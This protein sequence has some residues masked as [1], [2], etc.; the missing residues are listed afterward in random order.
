MLLGVSHANPVRVG[1]IGAGTFGTC[2]A[3]MAGDQGHAVTL[4]AREPGVADA[5]NRHRRNPRYLTEFR[6]P[7]G[8]RG[9]ADLE[10]AVRD[11][12]LILFVIPSHAYRETWKRAAHCV[13]GEPLIVSATK[14]LEV[15]T[16]LLMSQVAR[17]VLPSELHPRMISLSGPSFAREL[18]EGRPSAVVL[19]CGNEPYAIAAQ[20]LLSSS[21]LRCYTN[22]DVIGVEL[23][24]ALK[25][26]IAIAV[27][28]CDGMGMGL[29]AR[30]ALISRG[31]AEITRLGVRMGARPLTF[32]GLSGLGDLILTCTGDLSRNRRVG[33]AI[34]RGQ[35]LEDVLAGLHEV[36]EGVPTARAA[37]ELA[38]KHEVD[39]PITE[40]V[41]R[42]LCEGKRP[43]EAGAALMS[44]QLRS[45]AE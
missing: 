4:W 5:M 37:H 23:G 3:M 41:H 14:G 24:G 22:P 34:G 10:E 33:I 44:R 35:G 8:V 1:V 20:A 38:R 45:E 42:V 9:T 16:G 11:Q 29:N 36:A 19:A 28:I 31:L 26:V 13:R 7:E 30:A 6:L 40:E 15:G 25:N 2:L 21:R 32:L 27:G 17:E 39:M 12:D 18:A 43:S